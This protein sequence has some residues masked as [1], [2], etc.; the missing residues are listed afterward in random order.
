MRRHTT[1]ELRDVLRESGE[2]DMDTNNLNEV[3]VGIKIVHVNE[4]IGIFGSNMARL[5]RGFI[6]IK[7]GG[8]C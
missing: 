1:H 8:S 7:R 6:W 3:W 4:P 5:E 2:V